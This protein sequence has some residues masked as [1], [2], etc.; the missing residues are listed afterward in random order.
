MLEQNLPLKKVGSDMAKSKHGPALFELIRGGGKPAGE[1]TKLP[2]WL[3]VHAAREKEAAPTQVADTHPRV[4]RDD[5]DDHESLGSLKTFDLSGAVLRISLTVKSGA[6]AAF[7]LL[8]V[9]IGLYAGGRNSGRAAGREE[10]LASV[11][12]LPT[13]ELE[14]VRNSPPK[15]QVVQ[16]LLAAV[17]PAATPAP[18]GATQVPPRRP[19][20]ATPKVSWVKGNT[21]I[22]V[23]EFAAGQIDEAKRA[24]EYLDQHGI[25]TAIIGS[26]NGP[27]SLTTTEGHNRKDA[28]QTAA[29]DE[30]LKR[31]HSVGEKYFQAGGRF[32]LKGYF[33][34]LKGDSW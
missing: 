6:V 22:V 12:K 16:D 31:V 11:A 3:G 24:Q 19:A 30:L 14:Q 33:K 1:A 9:A 23:Q 29:S 15:P 32:R 27:M 17:P 28:V 20:S 4:V 10:A 5:W 26:N 8:I 34:T 18:G 21:Y 13:S 25:G 2:G 7:V